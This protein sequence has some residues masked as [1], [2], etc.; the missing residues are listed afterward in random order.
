VPKVKF[1]PPT[2]GTA[3][4]GRPNASEQA[5]AD[6]QRPRA[7]VNALAVPIDQI[8]PDPGQPRQNVGG[9]RLDDLATSLRAYGVLQPLLVRE[10]GTLPDGRARYRIVAGGRRYAA[11]LLVRADPE[12]TAEER[13][14]L[15]RLPVVMR[16]SE[17][18]S[19]DDGATIRVLQLIENLQREDLNVVDRSNAL[20]ALKVNLGTPNGKPPTWDEVAERVGVSKRRVLQLAGVADLAA[21]VQEALR[22]GTLTEK[23]TRAMNGLSPEQQHGLTTVTVDEGLTPDETTAAAR[24]MKRDATID[25]TQAAAR[26]RTAHTPREDASDT[27]ESARS[28]S[29]RMAPIEGLKAA[30]G[31]LNVAAVFEVARF[32]AAEG[33]SCAQLVVALEAVGERPE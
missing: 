21:P 1:T 33:W 4:P 27:N 8:E 17:S 20:K 15:D 29:P 5:A 25:A 2:L 14:R 24:A 6:V 12:A 18:E 28:W 19:K 26:T 3:Q 32:G 13:A 16:S 11:A 7:L 10:D 9:A 22:T 23:H 31:P 30:L